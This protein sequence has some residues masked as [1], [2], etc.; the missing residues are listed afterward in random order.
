MAHT[1]EC[2]TTYILVQLSIDYACLHLRVACESGFDNIFKYCTYSN[3]FAQEYWKT[4]FLISSLSVAIWT[5]GNLH[6]R[7]HKET[8]LEYSMWPF[9]KE[10]RTVRVHTAS[11]K[12]K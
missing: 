3:S 2:Y 10:R 11:G 9:N 1:A 8:C 4:V 6:L 12:S 5:A 7:T